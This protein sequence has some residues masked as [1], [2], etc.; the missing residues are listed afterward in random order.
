MSAWLLTSGDFV[1]LGGMD[2]ANHALASYLARASG[3]EVHLVAHRVSSDLAA[4]SSIHVHHV[5]RPFGLHSLGG[6]LLARVAARRAAGGVAPGGPRVG[7][8]ASRLR[9]G[10]RRGAPR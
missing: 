1:S 9:C 8:Y 3:A 5:P 6:P 10:G 4:Q 7:R 2:T